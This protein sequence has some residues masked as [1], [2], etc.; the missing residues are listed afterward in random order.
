MR[1]FD[2]PRPRVVGPIGIEISRRSTLSRWLVGCLAIGQPL[3]QLAH[4]CNRSPNLQGHL[5]LLGVK[6]F[7][8]ILNHLLVRRFISGRTAEQ[9]PE[10]QPLTPSEW[11]LS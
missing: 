2:T 8:E 9:Q 1:Y 7:A 4:R 11:T 5:Q 3:S 6:L 10:P